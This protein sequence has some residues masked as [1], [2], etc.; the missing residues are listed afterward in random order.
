MTELAE[1]NNEKFLN[2]RKLLFV[3]NEEQ[4]FS[5]FHLFEKKDNY[6]FLKNFRSQ[7][8]TH[9]IKKFPIS[10]E[11]LDLIKKHIEIN[12]LDKKPLDEEK[13]I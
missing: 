7:N 9:S 1:E 4:F 2:N 3:L 12:A 10:Q 8:T 13:K 5:F 6:D 11:E